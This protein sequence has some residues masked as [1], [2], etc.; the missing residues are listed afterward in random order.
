VDKFPFKSGERVLW[1][2][3]HHDVETATL[4]RV[5]GDRADGEKND[6]LCPGCF[7]PFEWGI[8]VKTDD[9]KI[10]YFRAA[11][12]ISKIIYPAASTKSTTLNVV[13]ENEQMATVKQVA[14]TVKKLAA[15][16]D[17]PALKVTTKAKDATGKK[18]TV[19][20]KN[21]L[22]AVAAVAFPTHK[23]TVAMSRREL[24]K[25]A[26]ARLTKAGVVV[27]AAVHGLIR[28][29]SYKAPYVEGITVLGKNVSAHVEDIVPATNAQ[30]ERYRELFKIHN[31]VKG[32]AVA[33]VKSPTKL[34]GYVN[35]VATLGDQ[36]TPIYDVAF[37]GGS[38]EE[39]EYRAD[40]VTGF[41][42]KLPSFNDIRVLGVFIDPKSGKVMVKTKAAIGLLKGEAVQAE[43]SDLHDSPVIHS[44]APGSKTKTVVGF[45][46][47]ADEVIPY[48]PTG[49]ELFAAV[50]K[51]KARK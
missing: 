3:P 49:E 27:S 30:V 9:N 19:K 41:Q 43:V 14:A 44:V 47:K 8:A 33:L 34:L 7:N 42:G 35:N 2:R 48:F 18:V 15:L 25:T 11:S 31:L 1:H 13:K 17:T 45:F 40:E 16:K 36:Q 50:K 22:N 24:K 6:V 38:G 46:H 4:V 39:A 32:S 20:R 28:V 21:G 23:D 26:Q 37:V 12:E 10:H 51:S 29:L 5:N